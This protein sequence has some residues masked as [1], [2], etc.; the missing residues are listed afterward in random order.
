MSTNEIDRWYQVAK[1]NGALG[2]KLIGAGGGGFLMLYCN[3]G[4]EGLRKAMEREG[5]TE[6][7]FHFDPEGSKIIYNV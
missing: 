3:N 7:R 5:L 2:A 6:H 1:A 4:R